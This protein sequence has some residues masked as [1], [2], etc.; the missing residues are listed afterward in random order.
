[1]RKPCQDAAVIG[2]PKST[3]P[4]YSVVIVL[5]AARTGTT[6]L[7]SY[8]AWAK[9][10]HGLPREAAPLLNAMVQRQRIVNNSEAFLEN[11]SDKIANVVTK[12]YI[13]M[14]FDEYKEQQKVD[15]LIFRSPALSRYIFELINLIDFVPTKYICC[16]RD[17][18]DTCVSIMDWNAKRVSAGEQP[19][20]PRHDVYE[21]AQFFMSYYNSILRL[22]KVEPNKNLMFAKY[23]DAV[24][25]P[26]GTIAT[27]AEFT[28]LDLSDFDSDA[29]WSAN[30]HDF[31][32]ER[33]TNFAV[34]KL[35]GRPPSSA[36]VGRYKEVLSKEDVGIIEAVCRVFMDRFDY[37]RIADD[38]AA[39]AELSFSDTNAEGAEKQAAVLLTPSQR[40]DVYREKLAELRQREQSLKDKLATE[41][42][43][44]ADLQAAAKRGEA[45]RDKVL[46][47]RQREQALKD[48]IVELSATN[49]ELQAANNQVNQDREKLAELRQREQ[50]LK[51]KLTK[52]IDRNKELRTA[53]SDARTARAAQT[54]IQDRLVLNEIKLNEVKDREKSLRNTLSA[55][56]AKLAES[57]NISESLASTER[58]L[59][60]VN[61]K[62][63]TLDNAAETNEIAL[64]KAAAIAETT[65][66]KAAELRA[67]EAALKEKVTIN[68]A[69]TAEVRTV[70]DKKLKAVSAQ[71]KKRQEAL[72][73]RILELLAR[74]SELKALVRETQDP[75]D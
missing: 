18:R 15:T 3:S 50:A 65:L 61:I 33:D 10:T 34:T 60:A 71:S 52:I 62:L 6:L 14:F 55:A 48:K 25:A 72:E 40:A 24:T 4:S 49:T 20:L 7:A 12:T 69:R 31:Q 59:E 22:D 16:L 32:S 9:T 11:S 8:L 5:G 30:S 47:L 38:E 63:E 67:R 13:R 43:K 58:K 19:I 51:D 41:L 42:A 46:E 28:D 64:K 23:E 75:V 2:Q 73:A 74:E 36:Q 56:N 44:N 39:Q 57:Q 54:K 70:M 21:A 45:A 68:V 37:E 35:Y 17:P 27:L 53:V 1:M 66:A 26:G 29:G